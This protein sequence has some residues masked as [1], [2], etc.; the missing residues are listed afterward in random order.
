MTQ[1]KV[2]KSGVKETE[3]EKARKPLK[4]KD[5]FSESLVQV[6]TVLGISKR[7]LIAEINRFRDVLEDIGGLKGDPSNNREFYL[8]L[9]GQE[10]I[11]RV[12]EARRN[13][14]RGNQKIQTAALVSLVRWYQDTH[15]HKGL[16]D[17][18]EDALMSARDENSDL[19][20]KNTILGQRVAELEE[21]VKMLRKDLDLA[22][23]TQKDCK[24]NAIKLRSIIDILTEDQHHMLHEVAGELIHPCDV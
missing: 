6:M 3:R 7:V 20:D 15:V 5:F 2:R 22:K 4:E 17:R 13:K 21:V 1:T 24:G 19:R 12:R 11:R 8:N 10:F 18:T 16:F 14:I 9:F 23:K